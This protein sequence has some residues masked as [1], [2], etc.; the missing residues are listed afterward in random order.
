MPLAK[1]CLAEFIGT[2]RLVFSGCSSAVF[3][4]TLVG[5]DLGNGVK[6]LLGISFVGV[7]LALGLTVLTMAIHH[8]RS[9]FAFAWFNLPSSPSRT[10]S[11]MDCC[12]PI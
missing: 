1:R 4:A 10:L 12:N 3:A 7:S 8:S 6:F 9:H 2:F 5:A 11:Q